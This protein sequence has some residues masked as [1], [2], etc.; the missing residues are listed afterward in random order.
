MLP[1]RALLM[2]AVAL[3]ASFAVPAGVGAAGAAERQATV[4]ARFQGAWSA[5]PK[6]CGD[7]TDDSRLVIEPARIRFYE[8]GGAIAA[9]VTKGES[10]LALI[11]ELSG[12]GETWLAYTHFRLSAD[13]KTLTDVTDESTPMA[14][15]RCPKAGK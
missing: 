3:P 5:S 12:E 7:E 8:S 15:H 9:V 2:L 4:P 10:D 11:A 14:R 1:V 6:P 13:G